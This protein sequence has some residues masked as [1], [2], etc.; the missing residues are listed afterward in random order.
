MSECLHDCSLVS[1]YVCV[2]DHPSVCMRACVHACGYECVG[3]RV[4]LFASHRQS[5][6]LSI[7]H[8]AHRHAPLPT[9][10]CPIVDT[11]PLEF[12]YVTVPCTADAITARPTSYPACLHATTPLLYVNVLEH[13]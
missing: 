8:T 7:D 11:P 6:T 3:E 9:Q 13:T 12:R 5:P 4:L 10:F 2:S 1:V